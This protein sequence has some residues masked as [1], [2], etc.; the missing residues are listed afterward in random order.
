MKTFS[1]K[2]LVKSNGKELK[3]GSA[4]NT[5]PRWNLESRRPIPQLRGFRVTGLATRG[6][7]PR[8]SVSLLRESEA[9]TLVPPSRNTS[10][11]E[12]PFSA[13]SLSS[14]SSSSG[15]STSSSSGGQGRLAWN[16]KGFLEAAMANK[17]RALVPQFPSATIYDVLP[18]GGV[19]SPG[20]GNNPHPLAGRSCLRSST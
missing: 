19:S 14:S 4:Q 10:S 18:S 20:N 2:P 11:R 1:S 15:S 13:S 7:T 16:S 9:I 6:T 17:A 3:A 5:F 8:A 12:N